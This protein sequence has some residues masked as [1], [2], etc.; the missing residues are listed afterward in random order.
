MRVRRLRQL[1]LFIR[2]LLRPRVA[3]P[4]APAP[5]PRGLSLTA[6]AADDEPP[7][8][9]GSATSSAAA[10]RRRR[11]ARPRAAAP[12]RTPL[13]LYPGAAGA[14]E[15]PAT[16]PLARAPAKGYGSGYGYR[17]GYESAHASAAPRTPQASSKTTGR[18]RR[19]PIAPRRRTTPRGRGGDAPGRSIR[20]GSRPPRRRG[21]GLPRTSL[22]NLF[23]R[24]VAHREADG[25]RVQPA[26]ASAGSRVQSPAVQ[27]FVIKVAGAVA[28]PSRSGPRASLCGVVVSADGRI[29]ESSPAAGGNASRCAT[30]RG[31]V[32][33]HQRAG[34]G[35]AIA[36]SAGRGGGRTS[37]RAW[38][39]ERGERRRTGGGGAGKAEVS[40]RARVDGFVVAGR[41][42]SDAGLGGVGLRRGRLLS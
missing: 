31:T 8:P 12:R 13:R 7:P 29:V 11:S 34:H 38:T 15:A 40:Q 30:R 9:F 23:F 17:D 27:T 2:R 24:L 26:A 5:R 32:Q 21:V 14:A 33:L 6:T 39:H 10:A 19:S 42:A 36:C 3:L 41:A 28:R 35:D 4:S 25:H 22:S 1:D 18:R 37:R 20:G 16:V